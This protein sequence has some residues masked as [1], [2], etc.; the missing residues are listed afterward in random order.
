MSWRDTFETAQER[1]VQLERRDYC[2]SIALHHIRER[3]HLPD[4]EYYARKDLMYS[5][6]GKFQEYPMVLPS[7]SYPLDWWQAFKGRWFPQW[8]LKRWPVRNKTVGGEE[9]T[10]EV[11]AIFPELQPVKERT[12]TLVWYGWREREQ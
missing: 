12:K 10:I 1:R 9:K 3:E 11:Y 5:V 7:Y 8:A 6:Y 2:I 4:M